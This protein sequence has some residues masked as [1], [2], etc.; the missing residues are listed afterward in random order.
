MIFIFKEINGISIHYD[1][2]G[3]GKDIIL[4]HGWGASKESF[5]WLSNQ[6]KDYSLIFVDFPGFGE[7]PE[8]Q[9]PYSVFDYVSKLKELL[10]EFFIESLTLIGHSFGGRVAIKFS[11][12]FQNSY[13]E[14][15]L[16]LVDSAGIKPRRNLKYYYNVVKYRVYKNIFPNSPKLLEF[17][18]KDYKVLSPI[19]K[20]TFIKQINKQ[21]IHK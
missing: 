13:Q 10:D 2:Y 19:M 1:E 21:I 5:L 18:S 16:C 6:F 8:P 15:K 14:F 3:S 11:F 4:L 9:R 7:S 20:Q 12:L 17:G